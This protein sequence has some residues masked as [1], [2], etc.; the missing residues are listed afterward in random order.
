MTPRSCARIASLLLSALAACVCLVPTTSSACGPY[1][2]PG[3][4]LSGTVST[5][6]PELA[7]LKV[8]AR[9]GEQLVEG[10]V[11]ADG[12]FWIWGIARK[13][14]ACTVKVVAIDG[15]G[16]PHTTR[17]RVELPS[18]TLALRVD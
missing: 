9:C 10:H 6:L 8:S 3:L 4:T 15:Q 2:D 16:R 1:G 5:E 7:S 14:K 12:S 17:K 18:K 13:S 11:E